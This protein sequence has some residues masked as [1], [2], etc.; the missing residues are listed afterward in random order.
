MDIG[1]PKSY[2]SVI[3]NSENLEYIIE[4]SGYNIR[5]D[6]DEFHYLW[7][8]IK[9]DFMLRAIVEF[10]GNST[11]SHRNIDWMIRYNLS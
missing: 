8:R 6:R 9:G 10:I 3:Y 4:G 1:N 7:K 11:K 2:G 5:F